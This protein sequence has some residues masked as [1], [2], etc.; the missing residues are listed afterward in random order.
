MAIHPYPARLEHVERL[1]GGQTLRV[2]PIR[3]EDATLEIAFVDRMSERSRYM[4]FFNA[5]RGLTPAMLA[6]LTQVDYDRELA[7]IALSG[8]EG[9]TE[10]IVGVARFAANPDGESCEFAVAID[11]DWNGRGV[12]TILMQ[13]LMEAAHDA[14]SRRMTGNVLHDNDSMLKLAARLDFKRSRDEDDSALVRV[15]RPLA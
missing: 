14:G 4:R 6:R 1:R 3:P 9:E 12:A 10:Q 11:D 15:V 7:L 2:R 13:R 5:G 8:G